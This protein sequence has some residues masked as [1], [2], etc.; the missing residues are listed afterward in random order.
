MDGTLSRGWVEVF[1]ELTDDERRL[2]QL[3]GFTPE[4][5]EQLVETVPIEDLGLPTTTGAP[6]PDDPTSDVISTPIPEEAGPS[7]VEARP[8]STETPA[9][10]IILPHGDKGDGLEY[11]TGKGHTVKQID[12]IISNPRPDQSGF[13]KGRGRL[14][15]QEVRLLTAA[16]GH[17]VKLDQEGNVRA[18]SNRNLPLRDDENYPGEVIRPLEGP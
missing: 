11:I 3:P 10:N 13:V 16:D 4:R 17:W 8:G 9:G 15:G 6:R 12:D 14:K 2:G 5:I 1:P 7:I 18:T